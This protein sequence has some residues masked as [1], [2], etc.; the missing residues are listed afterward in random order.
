[1]KTNIHPIERAVRVLGGAAIV[2]LAFIGPQTP[3]A[4]LGLI[5]VA[6]GLSGW[7]PPYAMLG[8][9]TCKAPTESS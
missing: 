4:W 9:S 5:P 6:T 1:M 8:F 7:C 3:W 2:S